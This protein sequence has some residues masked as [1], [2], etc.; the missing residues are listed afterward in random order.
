M[1]FFSYSFNIL[2][3]ALSVFYYVLSGLSFL[4]QSIWLVFLNASWALIGIFFFR[5]GKTF[6]Y[7]FVENIFCAFDRVFSPSFSIPIILR[8]FLRIW[9]IHRV[10]DFLDVL[11]QN[12]NFFR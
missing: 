10:P 5:V 11:C 1:V 12:F 6:F 3:S 8:I 4:V 7:D 9:S 2:S